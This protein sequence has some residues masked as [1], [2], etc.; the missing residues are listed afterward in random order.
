M[1][2][3]APSMWVLVVLFVVLSFVLF[4]CVNYFSCPWT[5]R[6]STPYQV[7][8]TFSATLSNLVMK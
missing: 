3:M 2:Q 1:P 7:S 5:E 8:P 4:S 6:V